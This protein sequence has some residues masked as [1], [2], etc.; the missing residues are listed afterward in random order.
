MSA[1]RGQP[2]KAF[3]GQDHNAHIA[4]KTAYL[5]D[6]L[7]GANPIM[8][9]VEPILMANVREHMVLRFQEQMGGLMKAQEGQV[10]QGAS[11]TAIMSESAQQILQANQLAAQGGLDSIEQ[12]N[13][14][15]QKQAMM[16]RK[17]REDKELAL[18]EDAMVEAAKIEENKKQKDDNLTAKVVTDLLKIVD[19]Q[20]LQ[21]G[22]VVVQQPGAADAFK[23]AADLAVKEPI[24]QP[25]NFLEQAFEAQ[26][27]DPQRAYKE[28]MA[29]EQMAQEQAMIPT[30]PKEVVETEEEM[31]KISEIE[32]QE[33]ELDIMKQLRE[34]GELTYNQEIGPNSTKPHHPT[35]TS[36]VTIGLGYDMKE[37]TAEQI[38]NDLIDVGVEEDKAQTLSEAAGLSGKEATAFTKTNKSLAITDEQQNKLFTKIFAQSIKQTEGDL[39]DMGY[40]PS[41][42][43][44]KEIALL[45]DYTYNVGTIK[46]FP[47]FTKAIVNKDYEKAKEEY[48]RESGGKKLTRRNKAT[49]SFIN[50]L[51]KSQIA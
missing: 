17:E 22:G 19:K 31:A 6:P 10:D 21:E 18:E 24:S 9:Q 12:Q 11:L 4:V 48:E 3:P 40:D 14:N 45:A 26:G 43:S 7:N 20:K 15:I 1:T 39:R 41:T 51:E 2:I 28:K 16:N 37:K 35:P 33:K 27:I 50:D 23:Q 29:Q 46:K 44:E 42:L 34:F 30:E 47:N 5:Q 8:K 36:G 38:M 49:L 25:Q 13:L 32:K